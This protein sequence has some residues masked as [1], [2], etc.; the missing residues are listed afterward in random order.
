MLCQD[1]NLDNFTEVQLLSGGIVEITSSSSWS[2][3]VDQRLES[4]SPSL[5]DKVELGTVDVQYI[6]QLEFSKF[7]D[8][9]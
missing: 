2:L 1:G 6:E 8:K 4:L 5:S 7:L 9:L 3:C